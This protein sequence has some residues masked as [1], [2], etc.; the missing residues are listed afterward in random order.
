MYKVSSKCE[1]TQFIEFYFSPTDLYC[2]FFRIPV[3]HIYLNLFKGFK[4]CSIN[5]SPCSNITLLM[6]IVLTYTCFNQ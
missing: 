6:S 3:S 4:F 2:Y 5:F 1:S